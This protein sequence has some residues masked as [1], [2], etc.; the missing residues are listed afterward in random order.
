MSSLIIPNI[1][2]L[3]TS[4]F[5]NRL[6]LL[7]L[8]AT[9]KPPHLVIII[10]NK[11]FSLTVKGV[12][13]GDS[14]NSLFKLINQKKI[15]TLFI[16]LNFPSDYFIENSLNKMKNILLNYNQ[17]KIEKITCL[18]PLKDFF[19]QEYHIESQKPNFIFELLPLL[20]QKKI[21]KNVFHKNMEFDLENGNYY[22]Q[23]YTMKE[24]NE[25]I[26]ILNSKL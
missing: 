14:M 11:V 1:K 19:E 8:N 22:F 23:K 13:M 16:E 18:N 5:Q 15:K 9:N 4:D 7:I 12:Q 3:L 24:V 10:N 6:F 26:K 2:L 21:I 17:I 25:N 20:F